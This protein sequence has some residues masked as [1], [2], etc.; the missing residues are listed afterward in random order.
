MVKAVYIF[1][2]AYNLLHNVN[3]LI[4]FSLC[5]EKKLHFFEEFRI[6]L[7]VESI[8]IWVMSPFKLFKF[9]F[10]IKD[11]LISYNCTLN[12]MFQN[13]I[14]KKV[15]LFSL[16]NVKKVKVCFRKINKF[17]QIRIRVKLKYFIIADRTRNQKGRTF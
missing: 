2:D 7:W 9:I 10:E 15:I 12:W 5:N 17:K 8:F 13:F 4:V 6:C 11:E 14:K 3:T 16:K 1:L